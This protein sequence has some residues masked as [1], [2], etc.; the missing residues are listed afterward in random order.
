MSHTRRLIFLHVPKT[1]GS[2]MRGILY[3]NY[4][5]SQIFLARE[6]WK[7]NPNFHHLTDEQK[8]DILLLMGH[9]PFGLHRFL[10]GESFEYFTLL[11]EPVD[12]IISLYKHIQRFPDHHFAAEM[13]KHEYSLSDFFN[14][15]LSPAFDN[16]QVRMLAEAMDVPFGE[17][18]ED[19][20]E[21]AKHNLEKYFP[22]AGVQD[23]FD[24]FI[25]LLSARYRWRIPYYR[26]M[27]V[28]RN[29]DNNKT[30]ISASEKSLILKYNALDEELYRFVKNRFQTL[31]K[32]T[33]PNIEAKLVTFRKRNKWFSR[34]ISL[35]P[36]AVSPDA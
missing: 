32:N 12:R 5:K 19:H 16:C 9:M 8:R 3:M 4:K 20:L 13:K 31:L 25:L 24:E 7:G 35:L 28:N 2:S 15:R 22:L 30:E 18:T 21:A 14:L 10:P 26:R 34:L 36:N 33:E 6:M 29:R 17:L 23:Q 27:K 11:R 1:A